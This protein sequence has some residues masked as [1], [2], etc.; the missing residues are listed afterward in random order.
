MPHL[1]PAIPLS[2]AGLPRF[3]HFILL[4]YFSF[5]IPTP[6]PPPAPGLP[7]FPMISPCY[8]SGQI[9]MTPMLSPDPCA[10][11]QTPGF[12]VPINPWPDSM[13]ELRLQHSTALSTT[14]QKTKVV[15]VSGTGGA[16][17]SLG[18]PLFPSYQLLRQRLV[19]QPLS[20]HIFIAGGQCLQN[21]GLLR[22]YKSTNPSKLSSACPAAACLDIYGLNVY[23]ATPLMV[24]ALFMKES[25]S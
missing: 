19:T 22:A 10:Y 16:L 6:P 21:P 8:P 23:F 14:Q 4:P 13:P 3:P 15:E 12:R 20:A 2:Q 5:Q 9:P 1:L 24:S 17:K 11:L 25:S 7:R 18:C